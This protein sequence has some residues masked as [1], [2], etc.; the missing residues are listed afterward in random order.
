MAVVTNEGVVGTV[1]SVSRFSSTV[2]LIIDAQS[3]TGGLVQSTG[4]LVL[5]EGDKLTGRRSAPG[6]QPRYGG[7]GGDVIVTSGLST[8]YPKTYP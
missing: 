8:I 1:V 6:P 4:D 7:G 5:V 2:L 3:A